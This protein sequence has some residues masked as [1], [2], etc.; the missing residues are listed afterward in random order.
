MNYRYFILIAVIAS[1]LSAC[2]L[3]LNNH[4]G[5]G[6]GTPQDT[7]IFK[8]ASA[9]LPA[10]L[11][12]NTV[13][14][15][16]VDLDNDG[17]LDLALAIEYQSNKILFNNGDGSFTDGSSGLPVQK[18]DTR[19]LNVADFDGDGAPD[20][21]FVS[22]QNESSELYLN[23]GK[24][25][26]T[27]LSQRIP[28]TGNFTS[29]ESWDINGDGNTDIMIGLNGQNIILINNGNA[30]FANETPDRIP[31]K[32]DNTNDITFGDITGEGLS[33]IV[34]AN[35]DNNRAYLNIGSGYFK[36]DTANRIPFIQAIEE[37][38]DVNLADVDQD[39]DLDL[40]FGNS[41]FQSG[42]NAQDRLLINDGS[43]YFSD[44]TS[45]RLP[46]LTTDTF[47]ADF[48][49]LDGDGDLDLVVGNY[50]GGV[51]VLINNGSGFFSDQSSKWVP[52]NFNPHVND[53]EIADYNGDGLLD[54][55]IAVQDGADQLLIQK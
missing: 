23:Q 37:T 13:K 3:N 42:S 35:T 40:Y 14:A 11:S 45:D 5:N 7:T 26:F 25:T 28:V 18:F 31:T 10:G 1:T 20:L 39:G 12:N 15:K 55:Y 29:C 43:G 46:N 32:F 19:D 6:N 41:G 9:D 4:D 49:D 24:G 52:N 54:I 51:R 30:Y 53:L 34:I 48:G 27:D 50:N 44:K 47:D 36:D 16:A 8:N 2:H 38:Q 22:N 21:F 17:D 33:D